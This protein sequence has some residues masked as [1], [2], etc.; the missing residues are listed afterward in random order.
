MVN[1]E[2][3]KIFYV[4]IKEPIE[5]RRNLLEYS[6]MVVKS[7]QKYER[8]KDLRKQK[9]E[10][11]LNLKR[12]IKEIKKLKNELVSKLPETTI[13]VEKKKKKIFPKGKK[14]IEDEISKRE[15]KKMSELEKLEAELGSIEAKLNTLNS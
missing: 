2:K 4:E 8:F 10:Y 7:L 13:K 12:I 6:K 5:L 15:I 1:Q 3:E 14:E 11:T 9:I